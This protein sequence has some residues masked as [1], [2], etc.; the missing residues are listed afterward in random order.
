MYRWAAPSEA[1][2]FSLSFLPPVSVCRPL[3]SLTALRPVPSLQPLCHLHSPDSL[4]TS[5]SSFFFI[6]RHLILRLAYTTC[7]VP[8]ALRTKP[9]VGGLSAQASAWPGLCRPCQPISG[10]SIP[11][12]IW[13]LLMFIQ[14]L[15]QGCCWHPGPGHRYENQGQTQTS[16]RVD[17]CRMN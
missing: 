4:L 3:P 9:E 6:C 10:L 5:S 2:M 11:L 13:E 8:T 12:S 15:L 17:R 16:P 14:C 7:T 1:W